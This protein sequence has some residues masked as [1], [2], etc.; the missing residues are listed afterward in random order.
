[1]GRDDSGIVQDIFRNHFD[2]GNDLK[3][4]I[5]GPKTHFQILKTPI[6]SVFVRNS[7]CGSVI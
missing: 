6:L 3:R 7:I 2:F 1:M 4:S 5:L